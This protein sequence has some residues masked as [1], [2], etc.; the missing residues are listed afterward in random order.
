MCCV[1]KLRICPQVFKHMNISL[2]IHLFSLFMSRNHLH[3]KLTVNFLVLIKLGLN[4]CPKWFS[5]AE[6]G[7]KWGINRY[8]KDGVTNIILF[9]LS[10]I[11]EIWRAV[12]G[13]LRH[14]NTYILKTHTRRWHLNNNFSVGVSGRSQIPLVWHV[15]CQYWSWNLPAETSTSFTLYDWAQAWLNKCVRTCMHV[16]L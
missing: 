1:D 8:K 11:S 6:V 13:N 5:L 3:V 9:N 10:L 2:L 12:N 16:S 7:T 4:K 15:F 14:R